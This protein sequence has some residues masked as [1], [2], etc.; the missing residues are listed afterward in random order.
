LRFTGCKEPWILQI[1]EGTQ[2]SPSVATIKKRRFQIA[3]YSI[4]IESPS[5]NSNH[6]SVDTCSNRLDLM[7]R[8]DRAYHLSDICSCFAHSQTPVQATSQ[9]HSTPQRPP[10]IPSSRPVTRQ[11]NHVQPTPARIVAISTQSSLLTTC[12]KIIDIV[13]RGY[14]STHTT[15]GVITVIACPES[16]YLPIF[17]M[18]SGFLPINCFL[19]IVCSTFCSFFCT[20]FDLVNY[21]DHETTGI[22]T[23][24]RLQL[25]PCR[26]ARLVSCCYARHLVMWTCNHN[27]AKRA[28]KRLQDMECTLLG[29]RADFRH[30]FASDWR[31]VNWSTVQFRARETLLVHNIVIHDRYSRLRP[32]G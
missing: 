21:G 27:G 5:L 4:S 16:S 18:D 20:C 26:R 7:C 8:M 13:P 30:H 1:H 11:A 25:T 28:H 6:A 31:I 22:Y 15:S 9:S 10:S 2:S 12:F 32:N 17:E 14:Q 3:I 19:K 24:D 29:R 23:A